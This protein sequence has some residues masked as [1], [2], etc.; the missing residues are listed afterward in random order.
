MQR[1]DSVAIVGVGLIGASIGLAIQQRKLVRRVIGIG[2]R[3]TTLNVARKRGAVTEAT[4]D[5]EQGVA[6]ADLVIVC[7]PVNKIVETV[8]RTA[9][10]CRPDCLLTDVGSTKG[11][12]VAALEASLTGPP[13]FLGSHPLAGSENSGP[14]HG[15]ADLLEGRVVVV[16]PTPRSRDEDLAALEQFWS[17]LGARVLRMSPAEH[18]EAV[19]S[20]SHL[21]HLIAA[22]IAGATPTQ[23]AAL[24]ATGWLDTTRIAAADPQLWRQILLDN[25]DQVLA[26]LDR[27]D[28]TL[29]GL[30]AALERGDG[31]ELEELL[32]TAKRTRDALGS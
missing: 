30:R 25:R 9:R 5:L 21:P 27:F 12:I 8:E 13:H 4:T 24:V 29:A 17:S 7:T 28:Q 19:A 16:T 32:T 2:R 1:L 14:E 18:D 11:A 23:Y 10:A 6:Q 15:R 22:A 20:T 26:C 31:T 3:Q